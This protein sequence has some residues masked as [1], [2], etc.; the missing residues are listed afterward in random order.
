MPELS[1][2]GNDP[3][4]LVCLKTVGVFAILVLQVELGAGVGSEGGFDLLVDACRFE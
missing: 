4:W 2:F 1:A 3:F